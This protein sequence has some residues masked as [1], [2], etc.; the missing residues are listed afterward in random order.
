MGYKEELMAD[1]PNILFIISDDH[2]YNAIGATGNPTVQTPVLDAIARAGTIMASTHINGGVEGAVCVPCRACVNT[3]T[4]I[5]RATESVKIGDHSKTNVIRSGAVTMPSWFRSHGYHTY[6]VGKWH[7]DKGSFQTGFCGGDA[8]FFSGMSDHRQVP[9]YSYNAAGEYAAEAV[10]IETTFST[11]LFTDSAIN[12]IEQYQSENP[13]FLYLA[14]TSPHDPRTAPEPYASMYD[15][16]KIPLPP[17]YMNEHL[18]DNGELV[19]RDEQLA[20]Y[21]RKQEEVRQ[22]IADYYAMIT[23]MDHAI[24]KVVQ[25]LIDS[26]KVEN[27][28]IVYTA[29]HGLAVGQHALMG[30]QNLYDHSIRVPW[31]LKGLGVPAGQTVNELVYQFDIFPTL[32]ELTGI[33]APA[34]I[35]GKSMNG[36]LQG[37]TGQGRDTIYS[38]YKDIQR[39][40][41]DQRWKLIQYRRSPLTGQG[42]DYV[43]LFDLENDP[44]ELVNLAADPWC[45]EQIERLSKELA[46]SMKQVDDPYMSNFL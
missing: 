33:E 18:F 16:E 45:N 6:A 34:N 5:F 38:I 36:L 8:I 9:V 11:D 30:K 20:A 13:F 4:N 12:F 32:C 1:K 14:Y 44:W 15:P 24:G 10:K 25:A 28:L 2:R 46:A 43:Q 26:G 19:I 42:T 37:E 29:D 39:M 23:H 21:P 3:G 22:H 31:L 35:E 41:K 27:T 40:V 17:N 7:N